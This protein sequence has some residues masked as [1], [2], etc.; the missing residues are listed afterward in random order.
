MGPI[1]VKL[2]GGDVCSKRVVVRVNGLSLLVRIR[3][4][5]NK[6]A[7]GYITCISLLEND[8]DISNIMDRAVI[9]YVEDK[10]GYALQPEG[11]LL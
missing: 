7:R 4:W 5:S 11:N 2:S 3:Y 10:V 6:P 9:H 8:T 1:R